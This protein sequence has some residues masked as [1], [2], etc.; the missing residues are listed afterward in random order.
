MTI[1]SLVLSVGAYLPK[2]VMLNAEFE[3]KLE[4]SDAW[5][6]ERTGIK[7][8]HIA[9][10]GELT[11]DL[12]ANAG[13]DALTNAGLTASDIDLV[14]VAT[15]TPD[16]T[17]PSTAA[18]VQHKL[19][20]SRGAAF[21]INA[22]CSGF[23]YALTVANSMLKT[24]LAKRALVIGAETFS[25]ILDWSDRN[26]CI[27]FGDGAGAMVLEAVDET[28]ANG[29]GI[30]YTNIQTNGAYGDLL[31][32][33]G[34][35]SKTQTAGTVFMQGKEVFKHASSKMSQAVLDGLASCNL[36]TADMDYLIPHQANL[37]IMANV[38]EKL[39]LPPEKIIS[40]VENHANTSAASIPLAIYT[41]DKQGKIKKGDCL[42]LTA[43]GAGL[44]W[45]SCIINW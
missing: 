43:L 36:T 6:R 25:R 44:T 20:I 5:I 8:R 35:I 33:T 21:D 13:A 16:E 39:S 15:V 23:V 42:A 17:M 26:T 3:G 29:R 2:R 40:T 32:T 12:A 41:A 38:A 10:G 31:M 7:Q 1:T 34:G 45:G 18:R 4:T 28:T 19:G 9:A 37:R 24:G 30:R 14:I 22:A 11:S 27:L